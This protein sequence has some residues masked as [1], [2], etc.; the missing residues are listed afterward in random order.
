MLAWKQIKSL[1][2]KNLFYLLAKFMA[3]ILNFNIANLSCVASVT[4]IL[5]G[6]MKC[7]YCQVQLQVI[8]IATAYLF[9]I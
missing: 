6:Q 3:R 1:H 8:S 2:D 9:S 7:S 5:A 4:I